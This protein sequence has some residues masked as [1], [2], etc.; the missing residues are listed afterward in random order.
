MAHWWV[1]PVYLVASPSTNSECW[2]HLTSRQPHLSPSRS[3][4]PQATPTEVGEHCTKAQLEQLP[5]LGPGSPYLTVNNRCQLLVA[6]RDV[7][8]DISTAKS[9]VIRLVHPRG[10]WVKRHRILV[11]AFQFGNVEWKPAPVKSAGTQTK[12]SRHSLGVSPLRSLEF[13][14]EIINTEQDTHKSDH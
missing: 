6:E 13:S 1:A 8:K 2:P 7:E 4:G 3:Q 5:C 11:T 12:D 9:M 10:C 14:Y